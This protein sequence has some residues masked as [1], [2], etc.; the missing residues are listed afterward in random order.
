MS[1]Q[2]FIADPAQQVE[3]D[4]LE[5]SFVR[6]SASSQLNEQAH[7]AGSVHLQEHAVGVLGNQMPRSQNALQPT[8]KQLSVPFIIPPKIAV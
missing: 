3:L 5:G 4:G 6:L 1:V 8:E 2:L 7:D